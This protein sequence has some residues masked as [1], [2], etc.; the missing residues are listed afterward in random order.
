MNKS[1]I[2]IWIL[3]AVSFV[4]AILNIQKKAIGFFLW[5]GTDAILLIIYIYKLEYGTAV[6]F[7]MYTALN[8][9]GGFTWSR[10]EK[11]IVK[12]Q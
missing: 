2:L 6:L 8:L 3:V 5:A 7:L 1:D 9:Y 4:A 10:A 12:G 11:N